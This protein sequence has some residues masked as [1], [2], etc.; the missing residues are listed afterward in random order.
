MHVFL[1][2]ATRGDQCLQDGIEVCRESLYPEFICGELSEFQ[3][4]VCCELYQWGRCYVFIGCLSDGD[5]ILQDFRVYNGSVRFGRVGNL[6][7]SC[8]RSVS[9]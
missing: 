5:K 7:D 6:P 9:E 1:W 8:E 4:A 2:D 3:Y